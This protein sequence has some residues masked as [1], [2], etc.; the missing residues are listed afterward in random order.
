M[1][2][3]LDGV[4]VRNG[5]LARLQPRI[6]KLGRA[7]GLAVVLVG[8]D[9]ASEVYVRNKVKACAELNFFSDKLT[10]P[11]DI[12]TEGLL[13]IIDTLNKRDD[14]D[15]ILVQMPLPKQIDAR[16]VL[17][18]IAPEKDADG[19]HPMNVG[20]LV[21]GRP[22]P[23]ACTPAG[24]MELLKHYSIP[25]SGK[26]A[27][28]LGRSDIVGKPQALMLLHE[29]ATVTICHSRTANLAE[30][31]RRADILVAAIGKAGFVTA[32]F[33]A[34]GATV[35]DVGINRVTDAAEAERFGKAAGFAKAGSV[36]VGDVHPLDADR[37]AG[38]YTPVPGG[39]G[40]LTIAMLMANTVELSERRQSLTKQ[41]VI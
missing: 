6:A 38:A 41:G 34:P 27:V 15:G 20:H 24:V 12:S 33:I 36:L 13:A 11:A 10:P 14:I 19:F 22:G 2:K 26:R 30:E 1:A 3:I 25:V 5:I 16:R 9:P 7:P 32:E 29:S 8:H 23:R 37:V 39:V 17:E 40:P 21:A 35:I 4:A 28:V 18:A 31:C